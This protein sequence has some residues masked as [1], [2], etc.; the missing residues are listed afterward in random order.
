M[1]ARDPTGFSLP[2]ALCHTQSTRPPRPFP[3]TNAHGAN[4]YTILPFTRYP[5]CTRRAL[6]KLII[7]SG[8][9]MSNSTRQ[10]WSDA[11][12]EARK[13]MLSGNGGV[14][15]YASHGATV[16]CFVIGIIYSGIWLKRWWHIKRSNAELLQSV[17]R[18]TPLFLALSTATCVFGTAAWISKLFR[19]PYITSSERISYSYSSLDV[20]QCRDFVATELQASHNQLSVHYQHAL[21]PPTGSAQ[22]DSVSNS[23][24]V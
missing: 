15:L 18:F 19:V 13:Q 9:A 23:L 5:R 1:S 22:S 12:Q 16:F 21:T 20:S 8:D 10:F 14:V 2:E 17:W 7:A 3:R 11:C 6:F 24:R 4:S